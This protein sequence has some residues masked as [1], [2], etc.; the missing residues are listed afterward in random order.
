VAV[1]STHLYWV[2][3]DGGPVNWANLDG[4]GAVALF[5]NQFSWGVAVGP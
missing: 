3:P 1:T 5:S 2:N 4:S